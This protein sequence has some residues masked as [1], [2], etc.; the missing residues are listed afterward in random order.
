MP[1]LSPDGH[2]ALVNTKGNSPKRIPPAT[3]RL[4]ESDRVFL[5][6]CSP[7][8]PASASSTNLG[9]QS[10]YVRSVSD[11]PA[12]PHVCRDCAREFILPIHSIV[13]FE[14]GW[15]TL[16][17]SSWTRLRHRSRKWMSGHA[18]IALAMRTIEDSSE[19][20]P[21]NRSG[22]TFPPSHGKSPFSLDGYLSWM[23]RVG[24][25]RVGLSRVGRPASVRQQARKHGR[26]K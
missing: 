24:L 22:N 15:L 6:G 14:A 5:A 2:S 16:I 7:A 23:S 9:Y 8:V 20:N 21:I 18:A 12:G 3:H 19:P 13:C 4:D 26:M 1:I 25:S 10:L 17:Q 11:P